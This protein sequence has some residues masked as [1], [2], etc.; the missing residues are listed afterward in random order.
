MCRYSIFFLILYVWK[1]RVEGVGLVF[2]LIV[3]L[4]FTSLAWCVSLL[5]MGAFFL[6]LFLVLSIF[7]LLWFFIRG[8]STILSLFF[9]STR[10]VAGWWDV[11]PT[12]GMQICIKNKTDSPSPLSI[13][14][15]SCLPHF[16][17]RTASR[18]CSRSSAVFTWIY[19][20]REK[21]Q[22]P[23]FCTSRFCS[24]ISVAKT[25]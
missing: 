4:P 17:R 8:C 1:G 2:Y 24:Q 25:R 23:F 19:S 22:Q 13:D 5:L 14:F 15:N 9:Y 7:F 6:S 10:S 20:S 12:A 18:R 3:F 21:F 16:S 11:G